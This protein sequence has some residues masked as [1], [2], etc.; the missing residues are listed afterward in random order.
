MK[1]KS[2]KIYT[3]I[4]MLFLLVGI[5][6]ATCVTTTVA[7]SSDFMGINQTTY[8][9]IPLGEA[10]K[11]SDFTF[12]TPRL[13]FSHI[14]YEDLDGLAAGENYT[15]Q[16][17]MI[18]DTFTSVNSTFTLKNVS[19]TIPVTN[20][21]LTSTDNHTFVI[22]FLDS[23][24]DGIGIQASWNRTFVKNVDDIF[25]NATGMT[26]MIGF[27]QFIQSNTPADYGDSKLFRPHEATYYGEAINLTNWAVGWEYE[28]TD[29]GSG[30]KTINTTLLDIILTMFIIGMLVFIG[31]SIYSG[32][33]STKSV[34]VVVISFVILLVFM[35]IL[36]NILGGVCTI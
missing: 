36:K 5:A 7:N 25:L 14:V 33:M 19:N 2:F 8:S 34:V 28:E 29:C 24:Y 3:T 4:L 32:G 30:C 21:T 12:F 22:R 26:G 15:I 13:N 35:I 10:Q 6:S 9:E 1:Q 17:V 27:A 20:Y 23:R 11:W 31:F 18:A 16:W